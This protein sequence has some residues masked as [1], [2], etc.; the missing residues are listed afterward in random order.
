MSRFKFAGL[1]R[2]AAFM[3]GCDRTVPR[4]VTVTVTSVPTRR[5]T[6]RLRVSGRLSGGDRARA[7]CRGSAAIRN[8]LALV[9]SD[10]KVPA[11]PSVTEK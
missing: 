2:A 7:S 10:S 5:L 3:P 9:K 1:R 6:G 11:R 8:Y 4:T